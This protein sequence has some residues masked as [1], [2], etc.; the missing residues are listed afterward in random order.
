ML[1]LCVTVD[2]LADWLGIALHKP[3]LVAHVCNVA[4]HLIMDGRARGIKGGTS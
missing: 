2:D 4:Y 1:L 3:A